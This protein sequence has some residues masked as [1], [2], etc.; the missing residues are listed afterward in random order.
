MFTQ[1]GAGFSVG[2]AY[3][4][5]SP[6]VAL[7]MFFVYLAQ[8]IRLRKD[9]EVQKGKYIFNILFGLLIVISIAIPSITYL[10]IKDACAISN[11]AKIPLISQAM[12]LYFDQNGK[13]PKRLEELVPFYISRLPSPSCNILSGTPRHFRARVCDGVEPLIFVNTI[14]F[15]GFDLY[16]FRDSHHSRISSFLDIPDPG[17]CP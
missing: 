17:Y 14:D 7:L 11:S 13:Y 6:F 5:I 8:V 2:V 4:L 1:F 9:P 16:N 15:M 3:L 12:E 10:P